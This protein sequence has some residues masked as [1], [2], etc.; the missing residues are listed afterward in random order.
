M[1]SLPE[2]DMC[3]CAGGSGAGRA[4]QASAGER[5]QV[6]FLQVSLTSGEC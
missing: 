2:S 1:F 4:A 3:G 5:E 6:A